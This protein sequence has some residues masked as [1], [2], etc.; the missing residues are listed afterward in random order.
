[1][2]TLATYV[3]KLEGYRDEDGPWAKAPCKFMKHP[4]FFG[5]K[6]ATVYQ[7]VNTEIN[8]SQ[9][10]LFILFIKQHLLST[11]Q[12]PALGTKQ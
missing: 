6:H 9:S 4:I 10:C 3:I 2:L 7:E 11:S 12:V 8:E 5:D 1:M